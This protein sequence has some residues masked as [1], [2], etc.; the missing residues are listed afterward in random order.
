[1]TDKSRYITKTKRRYACGGN[2]EMI[3]INNSIVKKLLY[4]LT[5]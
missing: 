1:M 5:L 4:K 3:N 2:E